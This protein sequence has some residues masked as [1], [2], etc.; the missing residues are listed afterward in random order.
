MAANMKITAIKDL[1]TYKSSW[2]VHVKVLHTWKQQFLVLARE[3]YLIAVV[4]A[5]GQD[6]SSAV[7]Q[8]Q[9]FKLLGPGLA[10]TCGPAKIV[11]S[12]VFLMTDKE[13]NTS[14]E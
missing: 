1:K 8:F 3:T 14:F 13:E 10:Y 2:L 12:T 9:N 6:P 4:R 11:P 5:W 7:S